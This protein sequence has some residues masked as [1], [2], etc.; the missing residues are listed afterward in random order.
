MNFALIF[1][2]RYPKIELTQDIF[3]N[4]TD[5]SMFRY[6]FKLMHSITESLEKIVKSQLQTSLDKSQLERRDYIGWCL[7][8]NFGWFW[9]EKQTVGAESA[10]STRINLTSSVDAQWLTSIFTRFQLFL[11]LT[12][13][14]KV[15]PFLLTSLRKSWQYPQCQAIEVQR[16]TGV[17]NIS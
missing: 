4:F 11:A 2:Y 3:N 10:L 13:S 1:N 9:I 17:W 14:L 6:H 16:N 12:W 8:E 7:A 15:D 5:K